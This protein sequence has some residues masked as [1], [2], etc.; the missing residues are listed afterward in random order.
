[1]KIFK[2]P[3]ICVSHP[4]LKSHEY[5]IEQDTSVR[6]WFWTVR[7][8]IYLIKTDIY[9]NLRMLFRFPLPGFTFAQNVQNNFQNQSQE[10]LK[11]S[12]NSILSQLILLNMRMLMMCV[13]IA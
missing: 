11:K 4:T 13:Y 5:K 1:M 7:I 3:V 6:L 12:I 9:P 10:I 2:S 8:I